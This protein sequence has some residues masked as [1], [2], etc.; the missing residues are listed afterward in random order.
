MDTVFP[1]DCMQKLVLVTVC[2]TFPIVTTVLHNEGLV[3]LQVTHYCNS[4]EIN[5]AKWVGHVSRR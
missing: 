2:N 3:I 5:R 1:N 4:S